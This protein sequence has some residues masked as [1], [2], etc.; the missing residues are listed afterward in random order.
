MCGTS[1]ATASWNTSAVHLNY[2]VVAV[3]LVGDIS[4]VM[5]HSGSA[6][7]VLSG[8]QCGRTYNVSVKASSGSCSGQYSP[9][10]TLHTGNKADARMLISMNF[11]LFYYMQ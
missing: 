3:P 6:S 9:P 5:C 8:L 11:I 2:S 4:S 7:C 1:D 10:Q